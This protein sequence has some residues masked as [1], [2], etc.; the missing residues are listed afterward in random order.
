MLYSCI[1]MATVGVKGLM[2]VRCR[3]LADD[4]SVTM[5]SRR[6]TR[7]V[8]FGLQWVG[9]VGLRASMSQGLTTANSM[10]S[11]C[12]PWMISDRANHSSP[13]NQSPPNTS[14]VRDYI[15]FY[16]YSSILHHVACQNIRLLYAVSVTNLTGTVNAVP[17]EWQPYEVEVVVS[18]IITVSCSSHYNHLGINARTNFPVTFMYSSERSVSRVCR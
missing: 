4:Q 10:S 18:L 3:T 2:S 1:H 14:L 17:A 13:I 6:R 9:S 15:F 16:I 11:V 12:R 8:E 7:R 5:W